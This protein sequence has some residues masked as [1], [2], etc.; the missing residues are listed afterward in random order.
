MCDDYVGKMVSLDEEGI[1][2]VNDA[3]DEYLLFGMNGKRE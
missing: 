3:S 2:I 1:Q